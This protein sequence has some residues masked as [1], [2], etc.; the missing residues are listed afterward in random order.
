MG[1]SWLAVVYCLGEGEEMIKRMLGGENVFVWKIIE[2][3][4]VISTRLPFL[5]IRSC[6]L[7]VPRENK[8]RRWGNNDCL[9][10]FP[11]TRLQMPTGCN[12]ANSFTPV[13]T[14]DQ[15]KTPPSVL[16]HI[17]FKP[18]TTTSKLPEKQTQPTR[19]TTTHPRGSEGRKKESDHHNILIYLD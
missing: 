14:D 10:E 6:L 8:T 4:G 1:I 7:R 12:K 11:N 13:S 15:R 9:A 18:Q 2:I 19:P 5:F 3:C 16:P 17:S